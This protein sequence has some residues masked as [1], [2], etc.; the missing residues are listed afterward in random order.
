MTEKAL[1]I[2]VIKDNPYQPRTHFDPA[3]IEE[4]AS[5]IK[6]YGVLQPLLVREKDDG[7][8]ELIAGQRRMAASK[9]AGLSQVP[10]IVKRATDAEMLEMAIIENIHREDMSPIDK[11]QSFKQLMTRF[12]MTQNQISSLL[13]I[14][15]PAVANTI[16][17]LDLPDNVKEALHEKKITEGHARALLNIADKEKRDIALRRIVAGNMS[18][19]DTEEF[20][21]IIKKQNFGETKKNGDNLTPEERFF[22]EVLMERL[23]TKVSMVKNG[24]TGKIEIEYYSQEQLEGIMEMM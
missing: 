8:F 21:K 19:R 4:M 5:S 10:V 11:A 20:A 16:R 7:S 12:N 15:R 2:S 14:S 23:G 6:K 24:T 13:G 22:L 1:D 18:V 3:G 17:L 9:K